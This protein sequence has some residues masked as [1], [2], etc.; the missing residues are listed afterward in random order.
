MAFYFAKDETISGTILA[1]EDEDLEMLKQVFARAC[2]V[3][4][5]APWQVKKLHDEI[6]HG[7]ALQDYENEPRLT[8]REELA[9]SENIKLD[10]WASENSEAGE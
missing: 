1:T 10:S 5:N 8:R 3:W 7:H 2:N 6:I 4:P 9:A